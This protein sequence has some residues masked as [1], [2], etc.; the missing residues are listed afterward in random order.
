M[1]WIA[2]AGLLMVFTMGCG[3]REESVASIKQI[4]PDDGTSASPWRPPAVVDTP[5]F[6]FVR[7]ENCESENELPVEDAMALSRTNGALEMAVDVSVYC[8]SVAAYP[9][10]SFLRD[11]VTVAVMDYSLTSDGTATACMCGNALNFKFKRNVPKGT[12][13]LFLKDGKV[14]A[15][16]EAP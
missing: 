2:A 12:R 11:L 13:V 6:E 14:T 5:D 4:A 16:G 8:S 10:V 9:E 15:E 3:P 1:R 7:K